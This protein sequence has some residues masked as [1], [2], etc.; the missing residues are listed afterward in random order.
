MTSERLPSIG[1]FIIPGFSITPP[2]DTLINLGDKPESIDL[3]IILS[4]LSLRRG[5][6]IESPSNNLISLLSSPSF[7]KGSKLISALFLP[8]P[9][10][11][12]I[13]LTICILEM[14]L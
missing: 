1:I 3:G 12:G 4:S 8:P 13:S 6:K 10:P 11:I 7:M 5:I 14:S 9:F 2:I